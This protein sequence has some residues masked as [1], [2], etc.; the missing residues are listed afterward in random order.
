MEEKEQEEEEEEQEE[1]EEGLQKGKGQT[2]IQ[3]RVRELQ[4]HHLPGGVSTV[5]ANVSPAESWDEAPPSSGLG[6]SAMTCL[7]GTWLSPPSITGKADMR[8]S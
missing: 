2:Q 6:F 3:G 1:E 8:G 4:Y 5:L 7:C